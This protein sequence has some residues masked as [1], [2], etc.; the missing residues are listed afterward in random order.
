MK[1]I[2]TFIVLAIFQNHGY[3]QTLFV[4]LSCLTDS[5]WKSHFDLDKVSVIIGDWSI[6]ADDDTLYHEHRYQVYN[7][8]D[9]PKENEYLIK[10]NPIDLSRVTSFSFQL[11][12]DSLT[13]Y[14]EIGCCGL[15]PDNDMYWTWQSGYIGFKLEGTDHFQNNWKYHLGGFQW[16]F[17]ADQKISF[18]PNNN[19]DNHYQITLHLSENLFTPMN[20]SD[21]KVMSPSQQSNAL[22]KLIANSFLIRSYHE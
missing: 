1:W 20:Q 2:V 11:G 6:L 4:H 8:I 14:Q 10:I 19:G 18:V 17:R 21:F 12:V 3:N 5:I 7:F 13:H 15:E 22:M 16:P 9:G